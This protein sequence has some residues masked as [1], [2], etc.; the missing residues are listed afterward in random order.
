MARYSPK[1]RPSDK[2][3]PIQQIR[4]FEFKQCIA[5]LKATGKKASTI[6]ELRNGISE[7]SDECIFHHVYQYFLKGHILEYTNDFAQWTAHFLEERALAEQLSNLDPYMFHSIE[8]VRKELLRIIDTFLESFPEPRP[9]L[10]GNE[11][12]FSEALTIVFPCGVKAKN[13]AEFLVAIKNVDAES[14]YY[15][16]YEARMRL[17]GGVDDFS[18]WIEGSLRRKDLAERIRNIDPFMHNLDGI[19]EQIAGFV[20]EDLRIEMEAP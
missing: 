11:F 16:F 3:T 17:G 18:R 13:L 19:R 12:Y 10:A 15:H 14:I 5:I 8:D 4:P 1:G 9:V 2:E 6:R 20:E 7:V